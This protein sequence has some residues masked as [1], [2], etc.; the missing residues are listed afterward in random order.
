LASEARRLV[1]KDVKQKAYDPQDLRPEIFVGPQVPSKARRIGFDD[2]T[3]MAIL[4]YFI[5][6]SPSDVPQSRW[7]NFLD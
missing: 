5:G 4:C 7:K 1:A 3:G 2:R 6:S